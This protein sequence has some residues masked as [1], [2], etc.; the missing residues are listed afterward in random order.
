MMKGKMMKISLI[1]PGYVNFSAQLYRDNHYFQQRTKEQ[2]IKQSLAPPIYAQ[3]ECN[4][5]T[6][7]FNVNINKC[8]SRCRPGEYETQPCSKSTDTRCQPCK[9]GTYRGTWTYGSTCKDCK[10]C[11]NTEVEKEKCSLTHDTVCVCQDGYYCEVLNSKNEC[12]YCVPIEITTPAVIVDFR[13]YTPW[14]IT[15]VVFGILSSFV[16]V[17]VALLC[18]RKEIMKKIRKMS[19]CKNSEPENSVRTDVVDSRPDE[20]RPLRPP[21][22]EQGEHDLRFPIEETEPTDGG[23]C[24]LS[25]S[26]STPTDEEKKEVI[27]IRN[28]LP[29]FYLTANSSYSTP[30]GH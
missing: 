23:E 26:L 12:D 16:T 6:Q 13:D 25:L 14:V 7:Y 24:T 18:W 28:G 15:A 4:Q 3:L 20:Q 8:C 19:P 21:V 10:S 1:L 27:P 29:A 17:V 22:E 5:T 9:E 30:T 2:P 11:F